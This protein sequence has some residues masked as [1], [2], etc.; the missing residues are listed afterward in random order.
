MLAAPIAGNVGVI[1]TLG[2]ALYIVEREVNGLL[3]C[4]TL[5]GPLRFSICLPSD[6]WVLLDS[7]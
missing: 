6:F 1:T 3:Y 7:F 5:E 2:E 4:K